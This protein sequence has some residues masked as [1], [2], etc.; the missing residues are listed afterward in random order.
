MTEFV[1]VAVVVA[2]F[3][4]VAAFVAV[5]GAWP[6]CSVRRCWRG[7]LA[8][9]RT[10]AVG[11][12][13]AV[14]G[15]AVVLRGRGPAAHERVAAHLLGRLLPAVVAAARAR[16]LVDT[17]RPPRA[18]RSACRQLVSVALFGAGCVVCA[19]LRPAR[20]GLWR[21]RC[22]GSRCWSSRWRA[23]TRSSTCARRTSCSSCRSLR[24]PSGFVGLV[25]DAHARPR[26]ALAGRSSSASSRAT[27]FLHNSVPYVR[28]RWL[29]NEDVRTAVAYVADHYRP[30]D[31]IVVSLPSSFGF[32]YYWPGAPIHYVKDDAVSMGFVTRVPGLRHVVYV[33]GLTPRD[34][35]SA[36]RRASPTPDPVPLGSGSFGRTS[37][38]SE[39]A[40]W[41]QTFRRAPAP[42]ESETGRVRAHL[43]RWL[44]SPPMADD[45]LDAWER[46]AQWWQDGFTEGA[47]PEYEEQILPLAAEC[48]AGAT[49][50]VDVGTGEGQVAR[51]A[52]KLGADLVVGVDPTRAQLGVAAA[53]VRRSALPARRRPSNSRSPTRRST[54]RSRAWC[55][56]TCP[57]TG[58][59]SRRSRACSRRAGGSCSCSIIRCCR[60]PTADG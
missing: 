43:D 33:G 26:S 23:A 58:R 11:G 59:R 16:R 41:Q 3:S 24:L 57:T 38:T 53:R 27:L 40:S 20:P 47:D 18:R 39:A 31:V 30:G 15:L 25:S 4:T 44:G 12:G 28:A 19:R 2:L 55:S 50:V 13:V 5:A 22:S 60:R 45:D 14:V 6:G 34:T 21:S 37:S 42:P 46:N 48:L 35:T 49:R 56:S 9:V 8:R 52:T 36:M 1:A 7:P 10:V 51:L 32:S 54:P 29:P 17:L